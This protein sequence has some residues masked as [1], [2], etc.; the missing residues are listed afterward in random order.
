MT[1]Q[2]RILLVIAAVLVLLAI[3]LVWA[4]G[5]MLWSSGEQP[6]T[7]EGGNPYQVNASMSSLRDAGW[8]AT[9][10][11]EEAPEPSTGVPLV[12]YLQTTA[13]DGEPI[14]LEFYQNPDDAQNELPELMREEA[15]G[16]TRVENVLAYYVENELGQISPEN[17]QALQNLLKGA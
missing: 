15:P 10:A 13:P 5:G 9:E 14:D 1:R 16:A 11:P 3:L 7:S 17:L 6:S 12:G 4:F 2:V 8:E